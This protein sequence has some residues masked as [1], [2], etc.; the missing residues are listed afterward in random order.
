MNT[1]HCADCKIEMIKGFEPDHYAQI[2][3]SVWHPGN[4]SE[5]TLVGNLKLESSAQIPITVFRCAECGQLKHYA[6]K[7]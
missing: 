6:L 5:K 4:A 7:D 1:P 2:I 3:Q